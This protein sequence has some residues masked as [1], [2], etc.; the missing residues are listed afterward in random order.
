[1]TVSTARWRGHLRTAGTTVAAALLAASA[2]IVPVGTQVA[3]PVL[4]A[5]PLA[6]CGLK[7]LDVE[8]IIDRSGSMG[9][10]Q[11][12][13]GGHVRLYWAK[14]A[15]DDLIDAL[16]ATGGVGGG[17]NLH[18]VGLSKYGNGSASVDLALG[19]SS[20]A[21]VKSHIDALTAAG[22]TPL[23]Q[24]MAAG[25]GD[26]T[27]N[28]D[29]SRGGLSVKHVIIILS[30]GRPNP[31]STGASGSRPTS[32]NISDFR[33]SADV[34][35]SI[36]V[37]EGGTGASQI[38]LAL[39]QSLAKPAGAYRHV[40]DGNDLPSLFSDIFEEIACTPGI[41]VVKSAD[42]TELP[43]GGGDV[44]Y[45]FKVTNVGNVALTNVDVTDKPSCGTIALASGD[46]N[47]NDKLDLT[48][49]WTFECTTTV[50][51]STTDTGT[52]TGH[53]GNTEVEDTSQA[54]VDVAEPTPTP[55]PTEAPTATPTEA[56]TDTPT[57]PTPT[58]T[59][60]PTSQPTGEVEA[61]TGTPKVTLPPTSTVDGSGDGGTGSSL[62]IILIALLGIAVTIGL[63]SPVSDRSRRRSRRE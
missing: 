31:D 55:T 3:A 34:V 43:A 19:T 21:T 45:T 15:A 41:K 52:A 51:D 46:V 16:D 48:E 53:D 28:G 30:D 25:A 29:A 62:P 9:D 35:Y 6:G 12:Q 38:D 8:L 20:A 37:G 27:A 63:L 24:G 10:T 17:S 14:Q 59:A 1:M 7:P 49:T 50:T 61:A 2:A 4:A 33:A 22:N 13:S 32:T 40:V 57:Q 11:N 42:P 60:T 44:T 18:H 54:H 58:P 36:A 23:R 56:P 47:H 5:D 26:M 39:M